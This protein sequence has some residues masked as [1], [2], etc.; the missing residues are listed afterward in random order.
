MTSN[1]AARNCS[2]IPA[3]RKASG[4]RS[5]PGERAAALVGAPSRA[6]LS[7]WRGTF[8]AT[9][10]LSWTLVPARHFLALARAQLAGCSL[11]H[12][13][14]RRQGEA[15]IFANQIEIALIRVT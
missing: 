12:C 1:P 8:T 5:W 6:I 10:R 13:Q 15:N 14:L 9:C 4:A 2:V 7:V 11:P 3:A